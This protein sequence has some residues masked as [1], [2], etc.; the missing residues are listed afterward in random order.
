VNKK[1]QL[2]NTA[3]LNDPIVLQN[4]IHHELQERHQILE[5]LEQ[6][7]LI[8]E[9]NPLPAPN[10]RRDPAH[11]ALNQRIQELAQ[12][13]HGQ[14]AQVTVSQGGTVFSFQED[15]YITEE[16]V[17][18]LLK[19]LNEGEWITLDVAGM[20]ALTEDERYRVLIQQVSDLCW[21]IGIE[22]NKEY[23][24]RAGAFIVGEILKNAFAHGN[25]LDFSKPILLRFDAQ[26]LALEAVDS[27][28]TQRPSDNA[29]NEAFEAGWF[30]EKLLAES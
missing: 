11:A 28:V 10:E 2:I 24:I 5:T 12:R 17:A 4:H 19:A 18:P 27:R 15:T 9:D 30:A 3:L 21:Q 13:F 29:W 26:Q 22:L 8:G 14:L 20:G 6:E 25:Q 23:G 16:S 1:V 7:G